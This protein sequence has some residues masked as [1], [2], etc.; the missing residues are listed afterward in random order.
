MAGSIK[1]SLILATVD[2]VAELER[3]LDKS[4]SSD[5][6]RFRTVRRRP[7]YR[8]SA[9]TD[10]RIVSRALYHQASAQRAGALARA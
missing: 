2:R 6:S 1:F 10:S 8:R 4:G 7:E 3:F 9:R 5:V